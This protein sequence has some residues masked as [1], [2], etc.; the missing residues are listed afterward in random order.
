MMTGAGI[1]KS[2]NK[3]GTISMKQA[4][5]VAG[6]IRDKYIKIGRIG[7][8]EFRVHVNV[9]KIDN[10]FILFKNIFGI[11][12]PAFAPEDGQEVYATFPE[13]R[14]RTIELLR[15]IADDLGERIPEKK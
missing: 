6:I 15:K 11:K 1:I 3:L 2:P 12:G 10:G 8:M 7:K 4:K 9:E 14:K 13:V 5:E